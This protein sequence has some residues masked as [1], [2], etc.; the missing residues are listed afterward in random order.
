MGDKEMAV[1]MEKLIDLLNMDIELE[2]TL[3]A[4]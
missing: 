2:H 4:W 3:S 1:T